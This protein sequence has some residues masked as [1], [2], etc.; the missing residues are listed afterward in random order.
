MDAVSRHADAVG[1]AEPTA[2]LMSKLGVYWLKRGQFRTAEPM[3]RRALTIDELSFGKDHPNVARDLNN[4]AAL[5][6]DTNRLADAEPMMRRALLILIEFTR[7]SG[8]KHPHLHVVRGSYHG[9]LEA[10]GETPDQIKQR[11]RELDESLDS[12]DS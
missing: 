7:R 1:M 6:H 9:L 11:L 3:M 4:L 12:D 10:L 8:H 2:R 5:L